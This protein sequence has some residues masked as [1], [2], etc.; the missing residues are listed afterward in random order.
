M[1]STGSHVMFDLPAHTCRLHLLPFL[2]WSV[3]W[4]EQVTVTGATGFIAG[5]LIQQ[6]LEKGYIVNATVRSAAPSNPKTQHLQ[7]LAA[8]FPGELHLF[9]A[10]LLVSGAFD[11]A[12]KGSIYVFHVASPVAFTVR[13]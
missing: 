10:D 8:A 5:A 2:S 3:P 13:L 11:A 9:E 12:V 4:F 1:A 6:L 7:R